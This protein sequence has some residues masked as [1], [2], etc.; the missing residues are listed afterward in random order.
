METKA[1]VE[2]KPHP[3]RAILGREHSHSAWV[4]NDLDRAIAIFSD[5]YGVSDFSF[6]E[7]PMPSGGQIKVAFAWAGGQVLEI[8]MASGPGAEF[9]NDLLPDGEFAIR[10]HHL[11]FIVPDEAGWRDLEEDIAAGG[12][13][14]VLQTLTGTFIDAY[15]IR[16]PELGHYLE[17][18]RPFPAGVAFYANVP[19]N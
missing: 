17:Y 10:F 9:Y 4:T 6:I 8:I 11:G 12:W 2:R 13:E 14:V 3:S 1:I 18:V 15:Y 7:G 5:R 16:A 19:E